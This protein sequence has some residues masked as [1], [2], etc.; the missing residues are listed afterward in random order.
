MPKLSKQNVKE[1]FQLHFQA[2]KLMRAPVL[3]L[4]HSNVQLFNFKYQQQWK[5]DS[6]RYT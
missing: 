1:D 2:I 5:N 3:W 4:P 6:F